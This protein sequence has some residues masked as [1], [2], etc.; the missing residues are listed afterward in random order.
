MGTLKQWHMF[1]K[2]RLRYPCW[3]YILSL[4]VI[5]TAWTRFLNEIRHETSKSANVSQ[6]KPRNPQ[7]NKTLK[8]H[9]W[10]F[11]PKDFN[12]TCFITKF[13]CNFSRQLV[14]GKSGRVKF[15]THVFYVYFACKSAILHVIY[16]RVNAAIPVTCIVFL[17]F[18]RNCEDYNDQKDIYPREHQFPQGLPCADFLRI[19]V[20][21]GSEVQGILKALAHWKQQHTITNISYNCL[22]RRSQREMSSF[23]TV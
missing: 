22:Q 21:S 8:A 12:F 19:L 9:K 15:Y 14:K 20:T 6:R 11:F 5:A 17:P 18:N 4:C 13:F 7:K 16:T 10:S 3:L 2:L 1:R 23:S